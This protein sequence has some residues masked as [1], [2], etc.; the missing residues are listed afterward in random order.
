L[1]FSEK[2]RMRL[3]DFLRNAKDEAPCFFLNIKG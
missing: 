2:L 1:I 3:F